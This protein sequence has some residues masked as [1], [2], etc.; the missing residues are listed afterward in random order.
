M[1]AYAPRAFGD[2][3][4]VAE[5]LVELVRTI[6]GE[7]DVQELLQALVDRCVDVLDVAASGLMVADGGI[8]LQMVVTSSEEAQ[9]V[10]LFQIQNDE[11]PCLDCYRSGEQVA[12][13]DLAGGLARW[14]Q[15]A[16][17]AVEQGFGSVIALP[18]RVQ[19]QVIGALNLFRTGDAASAGVS[20]PIAQAMVDVASVAIEHVQLSRERDTLIEQLQAAVESR[21]AIEQAKG[22]L[23]RHLDISMGEA[24]TLL[25]QRARRTRRLLKDVAAE[26]VD[27]GGRSFTSRQT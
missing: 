24:F 22:V 7:Y 26:T 25:R 5:A 10:E 19:D 8:G 27:D 16:R 11:G 20:L 3:E 6:V 14:P 18:M 9:I 13:D 4:K 2:S 1:N 15:F 17:T 21:V 12:V 23:A